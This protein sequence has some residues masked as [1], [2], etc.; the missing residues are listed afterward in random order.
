MPDKKGYTY[1]Q[2][3]VTLELTVQGGDAITKGFMH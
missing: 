3:A 2:M 1:C